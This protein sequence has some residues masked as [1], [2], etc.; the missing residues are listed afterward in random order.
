MAAKSSTVAEVRASA[1]TNTIMF[2][3]TFSMQ[4]LPL[5]EM[6]V[7]VSMMASLVGKGARQWPGVAALEVVII[8]R[9]TEP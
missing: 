4:I 6:F 8:Q 3:V 1:K 7:C 9:P 5:E 2:A